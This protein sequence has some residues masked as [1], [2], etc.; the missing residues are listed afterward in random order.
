MD[1][2]ASIA[3]PLVRGE[4]PQDNATISVWQGVDDGVPSR[5]DQGE[6]KGTGSSQ[7]GMIYLSVASAS[8]W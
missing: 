1:V 8:G 6:M 4:E 2:L 3:H 5:W 7:M